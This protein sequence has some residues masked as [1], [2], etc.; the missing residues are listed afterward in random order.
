MNHALMSLKQILDRTLKR[1]ALAYVFLAGLVGGCG[2]ASG[3][4][5]TMSA[6]DALRSEAAARPTD[7]ALRRRLL[8]A[9]MFEP[10]GD[11]KRV[12]ELLQSVQKASSDDLR[13]QTLA[14]LYADAHGDPESSFV[15]VSR[16]LSLAVSSKD[17]LA[18]QLAEFLIHALSGLEG[19]VANYRSRVSE[20]LEQV[21]PGLAGPARHVAYDL[22]A[23]MRQAAGEPD[24]VQ[25]LAVEAGCVTQMLGTEAFG[26]RALL[27]FDADLGVDIAKPLRDSYDLGPGRGVQRTRSLVSHGCTM[28]LG[29]GPLTDGGTRF[30]QFSIETHGAGRVMIRL[31]TPNNVE[32]FIDGSRVLRLDRRHHSLPRVQFVPLEL[33]AGRH[34]VTAK[35]ASRHPSP[36]LAIA[37]TP[38]SARYASAVALPDAKG[39]PF[40]SFVRGAIEVLRG[41]VVA[42]RTTLAP[43]N[44]SVDAS[45][46][47]RMQQAAVTFAD[48]LLPEDVRADDA[49]LILSRALKRDTELWSPAL[50][51]A[52]LSAANGRVVEALE[53]MRELAERFPKVPAIGLRI[54]ALLREKGWDDAAD[55]EVARIRRL[56]PDACDPMQ[57]ELNALLDRQ[58][59]AAAE[60]LVDALMACDATQNARYSQ[61]LRR[62]EWDLAKKELQRLE[63]LS[64]P[65]L[66]Y[67]YLISALDLARQQGD[68]SARLSLI[69]ALRSIYP[70]SEAAVIE[71]LDAQLSQGHADAALAALNQALHAEPAAQIELQ[72]LVPVLGGTHV[73][74]DYRQD[75]LAKIAAF[76]QSGHTYEGPQVLVFDYMAVR[77]F[78]DG[79][80]LEVVHSIQ[81]AQSDEAIDTLAEVNVPDGARVLTLRVVKQDGA[82]LEPDAI[83]GKDTVSMPSV[84]QG[85]YVELEYMRAVPPPEG[86]PGGYLGE[87]FYFTSY[88]VPFDHSEI[89][90]VSSTQLPLRVDPRGPAPTMQVRQKGD[91]ME[92]RFVVEGSQAL[93]A[94]P[95]SV[96]AREFVPSIRVGYN[97]TWNGL[98]DSLREILV[99]RNVVDPDV[100]TLVQELVG[101][102]PKKNMRLRAQRLYDYVLEEVE[103][104]D[105]IFSQAAVM[106]R[107]HAGNR[108]RVL[109][110]LLGIAG[111]P[112]DL[113]LVRSAA[114]DQTKSSMAD[115][116]TYEHL[117]VRVGSGQEADSLMLFTA[118]TYAPFGYVPSLLRGQDALVLNKGATK[119]QLK[120]AEVGDELRS[121]EANAVLAA[122]GSAKLAVEERIVGAAAVAWRRE[123]ESIPPVELKRR[124]EQEYV[125]RLLPGSRLIK[126][127]ITG[128]EREDAVF[129]MHYEVTID[130]FARPAARGWTVP[131]LFSSELSANYAG[132]SQRTTTLFTGATV[133][134]D[135]RMKITFPQG[136][137]RPAPLPRVALRGSAGVSRYTQEAA[138]EGDQLVVRRVLRLPAQRVQPRGYPAFV[139]FCRKVDA[140]EDMQLTY[141]R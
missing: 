95:G 128:R 102:T 27:S 99:D 135:V 114:A 129:A 110:Y 26:P 134:T 35:V 46:Y 33:A 56:V 69:E 106:L 6:L 36:V 100:V 45:P 87:R 96:A 30:I 138:Y 66:R 123:L 62:R 112:S 68:E 15:A 39:D 133:E 58:R 79:S 1:R 70:R 11:Q 8:Q 59:E 18:S 91:L 141:G 78:D 60:P 55:V 42:A 21:A 41:D 117:L 118:E 76:E 81:K 125:S 54:A 86:F 83:A 64:S 113:V 74:S 29:G 49:R 140:A 136:A 22:R 24:E 92:R 52:A 37:V 44:V 75:G 31:D 23:R 9:E 107:A 109:H 105:D 108:A 48:T 13:T 101:D 124:F 67:P 126:L 82:I 93:R 34:L 4:P 71:E 85:D 20:L 12:V 122:D 72:R 111:I 77:I 10:G 90:F 130:S 104:N 88:E 51:I 32:M 47:L 17:P 103:N 73:L 65:Q 84:A 2:T 53:A 57:A 5:H 127:Q 121:I 16:G 28:H 120:P 98:V 3:G 14:A 89:V 40:L 119:I 7:L 94:E 137:K 63:K 19:A 97:A 132:L 139:D 61:L 131:P 25:R 43:A 80:S 115:T 38:W 50:Q 116:D